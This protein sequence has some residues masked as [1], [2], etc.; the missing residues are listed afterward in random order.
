MPILLAYVKCGPAR[1]VRDSTAISRF[2]R[3]HPKPGRFPY[4]PTPPDLVRSL[5]RVNPATTCSARPAKLHSLRARPEVL[6][7]AMPKFSLPAAA[8]ESR[9]NPSLAP[10]SCAGNGRSADCAKDATATP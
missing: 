10:P 6:R 8:T 9:S 1:R 5:P 4:I 2:L 7:Y 3:V